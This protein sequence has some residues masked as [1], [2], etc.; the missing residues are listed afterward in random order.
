MSYFY[1]SLLLIKGEKAL[2]KDLEFSFRL[3]VLVLEVVHRILGS[4]DDDMN[5][6]NDLE[7]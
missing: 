6:L 2:Q 4:R 7:R 3:S 1:L 5:R